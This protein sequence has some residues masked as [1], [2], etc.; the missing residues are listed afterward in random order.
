MRSMP[1]ITN[2]WI[3]PSTSETWL[4]K[5][6]FYGPIAGGS[7][8]LDDNVVGRSGSVRFGMIMEIFGIKKRI[9]G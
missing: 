2:L 4:T 8:E 9:E 7:Y 1:S 3:H 6:S 5:T